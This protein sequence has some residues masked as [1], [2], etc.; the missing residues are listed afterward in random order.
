MAQ[1]T[2][3]LQLIK[4]EVGDSVTPTIFATN[5]QVL[6]DAYGTLNSG[7]NTVKTTAN[8]NS[9]KISTLQGQIGNLKFVVLSTAQYNALSSKDSNTIYFLT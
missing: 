7:V 9:T 1:T 8:S 5:F 4:P 6:D 2:A 3:N